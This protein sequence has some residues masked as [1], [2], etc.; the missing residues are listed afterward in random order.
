[1][2]DEL[3]KRIDDGLITATPNGRL[4]IYNYSNHCVYERA[5]DEYTMAAR[6][7]VL[8]DTGRIL[9]RPWP[10]FFNLN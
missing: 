7:L 8:D 3:R 9:A 6:G 2:L 1:M 5:W 10:K 4:T